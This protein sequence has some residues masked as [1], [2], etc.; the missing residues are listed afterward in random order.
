MIKN[1][2]GL[3]RLLLVI[4]IVIIG[5]ASFL[6]YSRQKVII[7]TNTLSSS[8][9]DDVPQKSESKYCNCSWAITTGTNVEFLVF[10]PSGQQTGYLQASNSY[11]NNIPDSSYGIEQ[12]I[13]DDTGQGPPLPDMN[14]FGMNNPEN[15]VY[16]VQIIS[17]QP[18]DY[19]LDVSIAWGPMNGKTISIDGT[20]VTNQVDKY[21]VTFPDGEIQKVD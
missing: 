10:S 6:Y 1:Q 9:K 7:K 2:K 21:A 16:E 19:H 5:I 13:G 4:A 17:R 12:G 8:S 18:G 3:G 15:G 11:V 14:Y 20:L